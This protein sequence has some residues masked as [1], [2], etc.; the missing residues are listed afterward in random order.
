MFEILLIKIYQIRYLTKPHAPP[1]QYFCHCFPKSCPMMLNPFTFRDEDGPTSFSIGCLFL[2]VGPHSISFLAIYT[3]TIIIFFL[4]E[5]LQI[6]LWIP[7]LQICCVELLK[8]L[9]GPSLGITNIKVL[10]FCANSYYLIPTV[11]CCV[12]HIWIYFIFVYICFLLLGSFFF[13]SFC[14]S[15]F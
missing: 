10:S 8:I 5:G 9:Y 11:F 4:V 6:L 14:F 12:F 13:V 7:N 2:C 15:F 3:N 1:T